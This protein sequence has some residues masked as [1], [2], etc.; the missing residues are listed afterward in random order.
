[1]VD[2]RFIK[3]S[4]ILLVVCQIHVNFCDLWTKTANQNSRHKFYNLS[5]CFEEAFIKSVRWE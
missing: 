2:T 3:G 5:P 4:K 1:M